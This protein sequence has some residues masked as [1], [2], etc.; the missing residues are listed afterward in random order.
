MLVVKCRQEE[1][2]YQFA[3]EFASAPVPEDDVGMISQR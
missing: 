3:R 1:L 2:L